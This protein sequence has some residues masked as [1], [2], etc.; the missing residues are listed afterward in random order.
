MSLKN[1]CTLSMRSC[2]IL[3]HKSLQPPC[4]EDPAFIEE[5]T[6]CN[7]KATWPCHRVWSWNVYSRHCEV[8]KHP[9]LH[10]PQHSLS[11]HLCKGSEGS[12]KGQ[13]AWNEWDFGEG[14]VVHGQIFCKS[15]VIK[16]KIALKAVVFTGPSLAS[17]EVV[18]SWIWWYQ[19]SNSLR[20][21]T[22]SPIATVGTLPLVN[23]CFGSW[24]PDQRNWDTRTQMRKTRQEKW[25]NVSLS[26]WGNKKTLNLQTVD[27][28]TFKRQ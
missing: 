25:I 18:F 15:C 28:Y 3:H 8:E 22:T 7:G 23:V 6:W 24:W 20:L 19:L 26:K 1:A 5:V 13:A 10:L 17:L 14:G 21:S 11:H 27:H 4:H 2:Y 16:V 12:V 9:M